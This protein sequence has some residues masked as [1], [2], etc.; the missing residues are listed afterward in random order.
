M[1]K[2][3]EK[4][5]L[6]IFKNFLSKYSKIFIESVKYDWEGYEP[7]SKILRCFFLITGLGALF[8]I[9]TT[10]VD[11]SVS[12][13]NAN[14]MKYYS[15]LEA[16]IDGA[17]NEVVKKIIDEDTINVKSSLTV[18]AFRGMFLSPDSCTFIWWNNSTSKN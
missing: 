13:K 17:E 11:N 9:Y 14:L 18:E 4:I 15:A 10:K 1:S 3:T 2:F 7:I 5:N 12:I 6:K 8:L 16:K